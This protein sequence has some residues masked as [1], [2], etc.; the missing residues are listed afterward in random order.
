MA[1]AASLSFTQPPALL[2]LLAHELRW[3][4]LQLLAQTDLR[5][6]ELA[7]SLDRP[8][9]LISYHLAQLRRGALVTERRS[10]SDA[11]DIYYSLDLEQLHARYQD[12]A[13]ALHPALRLTAPSLDALG[14][15]QVRVLFLCTRNSARSQM[16]EALLR[17]RGGLHVTAASAGAVA[18]TVHPLALAALAELGIAD[19]GLRSKSVEEFA[20]QHFDYVVTVCDRMR[21]VCPVFPGAV[22]VHWSMAD[23]ADTPGDA[24][25]Q[26]EAFV[27]TARQLSVRVQH[28]LALVIANAI[29]SG[30]QVG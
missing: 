8:L 29:D 17:Q 26:R 13:A 9:N 19:A 27:A 14:E 24:A 2:K 22:Q 16:A 3:N 1:N 11:R 30:R 12:A 5:V 10:S 28:F 7:S 18:T 25:V 4:L 20:G 23:P 21:E 15:R 6:Q